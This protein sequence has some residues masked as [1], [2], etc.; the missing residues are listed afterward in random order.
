MAVRIAFL[1]VA[2]SLCGSLA[3]AAPITPHANVNG[4]GAFA[5]QGTGLVWARL[6]NYFD[7]SYNDMAADLTSRGF[8][9]A[10]L[11]QVQT[12][13]NSLPLDGNASTW[14]GYAA[15][16]GRAPNRDLIWGAFQSTTTVNWA[17]SFSNDGAWSYSS[18]GYGL[19]EVPNANTSDADMNMWAVY[20]GEYVIPEPSTWLLAAGGLALLALRRRARRA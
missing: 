12:L 4:I 13:L 15:I 7:L 9:I 10:T 19:N 14:D 16:M 2:I 11:S 6:D 20:G 18:S 5:D 17:Y 3:P 8:F 1:I